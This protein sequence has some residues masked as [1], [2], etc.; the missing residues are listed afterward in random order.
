MAARHFLRPAHRRFLLSD[1]MYY[2]EKDVSKLKKACRHLV[3]G[4]KRQIIARHIATGV[5]RDKHSA[6]Y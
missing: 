1:T 5:L 4:L 3:S 6:S 2:T